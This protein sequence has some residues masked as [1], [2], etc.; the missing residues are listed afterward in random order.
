MRIKFIIENTFS[1]PI[2]VQDLLVELQEVFVWEGL[3]NFLHELNQ[4]ALYLMVLGYQVFKID[5]EVPDW[6]SNQIKED[7]RRFSVFKSWFLDHNLEF[8]LSYF[9]VGNNPARPEKVFNILFQAG[10]PLSYDYAYQ[11]AHQNKNYD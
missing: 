11:L 2:T 10:M 4:V 5:F 1:G 9:K 7:Y 8:K 6:C 3:N